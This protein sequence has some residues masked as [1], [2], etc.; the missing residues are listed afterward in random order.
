MF[1]GA[2]RVRPWP[3]PARLVGDEAVEIRLEYKGY[4]PADKP[5]N[6]HRSDLKQQIRLAFSDQLSRKWRDSP[7]LREHERIAPPH[8][9][10]GPA[11]PEGY[12]W[13][14]GRH[15]PEDK[16]LAFFQVQMCGFTWVPLVTWHNYLRCELDITFHGEGH[17][18]VTRE[19]D[20][21]N[22]IKTLFDALRMPLRDTE[23][24]GHMQGK[25]ERAYC[26]LEDDSLMRKFCAEAV[27][28]PFSPPEHRV[29][30]IARVTTQDGYEPHPALERFR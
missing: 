17:S 12:R 29:Q 24:P 9:D 5:A 22:R 26:L 16:S 18:T 21:D 30:I 23:V 8:E 19:G 1:R 4:I 2:Y 11:L 6:D 13:D 25:G 27:P 20:I 10:L 3:D 7:Q 14:D 15:R 28:S